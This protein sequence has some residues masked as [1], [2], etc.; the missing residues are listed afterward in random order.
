MRRLLILRHGRTEWN[1]VGRFQ[2]QSDP[3]LDELGVTQARAAA[4]HLAGLGIKRIVTSDLKRAAFTADALASA[5]GL[6]A[7]RDTRL[8]EVYL[9]AWQGLTR[10]EVQE[11]F[12]EGWDAW[13]G[14]ADFSASAS[15]PG[16]PAESYVECAVRARACAEEVVS[17][18]DENGLAALVM[19]G[20][21][22]R[23]LIGTMIELPNEYWWRM[24]PLGNC[25]WSLLIETD[26][27][28]RLGEHGVG[29]QETAEP[30]ISPD[31]DAIPGPGDGDRGMVGF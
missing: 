5:T 10:T 25:C 22:A 1:A 30:A 31:T 20:G 3:D 6:T 8:R 16:D 2:G 14:G 27:G 17:T 24:A 9:G 11:R 21:T 18:L 29:V 26:K 13:T 19:H 7:E 15:T 28:W 23:A 4:R 12:P